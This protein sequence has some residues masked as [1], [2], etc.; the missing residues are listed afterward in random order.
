MTERFSADTY[1]RYASSGVCRIEEIKTM[2]MAGMGKAREYYILRPTDN[3]A[4]VI[5][6][7]TDNEAMCAGMIPV[8]TKEEID[9]I[10]RSTGENA[11][12][13][14]NDRKERAQTCK[15]ILKRCDRKELLQL[16]GCMFLRKSELAAEGRKLA[17]SDEMILRQ[18]ERLVNNEL[19][20]VLGIEE[21]QVGD[22]IHNLL[23][24]E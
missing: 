5:Y 20:F 12:P 6:V 1:V 15:D 3:T 7:P 10:I 18:A 11:M 19:S 9:G 21:S 13:W 17:S 8:L 23:E 24:K 16:V 4:S 14:I 22:Y 2:A